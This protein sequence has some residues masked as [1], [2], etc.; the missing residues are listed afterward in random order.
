MASKNRTEQGGETLAKRKTK[1]LLKVILTAAEERQFG[2]DIARTRQELSS[3]TDQFD[4]VKSQFKS[5]M[6]S[7]EK[8]Q[9]RLSVLLNNG[10]E[11]RDV[12]CELTL[13]Y[14]TARALCVRTDTGE[15]VEERAMTHDELQREMFPPAPGGDGAAATA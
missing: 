12:E 5:K 13:D 9:N 10:Y 7:C 4:E 15:V 8:E 1:K 6:E 11:Y 14:T 2:K 3:V